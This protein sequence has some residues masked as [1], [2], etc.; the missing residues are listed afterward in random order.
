MG[1]GAVW[2]LR[3]GVGL[4]LLS[5]VPFAQLYIWIADLSGESADKARVS[6][7]TVQYL[8]GFIGLVLAGTAAKV[9]IRAA[10]WKHLPI[11]LW[12][13]LWTGQLPGSS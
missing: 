5:W 2:R 3:S 4:F 10:G 7:W 11:T 9:A 1:R 8:I 6:I 13:M 12:R